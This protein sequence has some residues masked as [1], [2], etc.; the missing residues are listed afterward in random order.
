[1]VA[2]HA[3][4]AQLPQPFAWG[5]HRSQRE[6]HDAPVPQYSFLRL[7]EQARRLGRLIEQ[8]APG[9]GRARK[10]DARLVR[11]LE[12]DDT[13]VAVLRHGLPA[14]VSPHVV[15]LGRVVEVRVGDGV[16]LLL[17]ADA[18]RHLGTHNPELHRRG[19]YAKV[20]V[21]TNAPPVHLGQCYRSLPDCLV[22]GPD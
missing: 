13:A 15:K 9:K 22:S 6:K 10:R 21:L 2:D 12:P 17:N 3:L 19:L 1:M 5:I 7:A 18:L 8:D 14:P 16:E 4:F 11:G 20:W